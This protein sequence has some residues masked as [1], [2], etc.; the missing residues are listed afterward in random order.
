MRKAILRLSFLLLT[1]AVC[2]T[3][4]SQKPEPE[5]P[6]DGKTVLRITL[7]EP[8]VKTTLGPSV[9]GKRKVSWSEGDCVSLN[10]TASEPLSGLE[11][12]PSR[13]AFTFPGT[14]ATPYKLLYP[15]S[16]YK[17]ASTV[18]LPAVQTY[19]AGSFAT[20]TE[21]LCGYAES[22]TGDIT[23]S[24]LCA[25]VQLNIKKDPRVDV[26]TIES[27]VFKGNDGEQVS[28][29]FTIDY[30]TPAL[31]SASSAAADKLLTMSSIGQPLDE[32]DALEIF[33][34]VPARNYAHGFS[35]VI[36][37]DAGR[38]MSVKKSSATTLSVGKM[39]KMSAFTFVPGAMTIMDIEEEVLEMDDFTIKGR[40]VDNDGKPMEGVV[41]SDGHQCVRSMVDG[42][43]Y[44]ESDMAKV[45][46]VFVS[47]P[48]GYLPPV[49]GGIPR[50]YKAKAAASVSGGVYDFGDFVLTPVAN[51]DRFTL[52][53]SA[54]P[55]PR[56]NNWSLDK[57]AYK[58]LDI[59]EDL[60]REL[61]DVAGTISD[62]QVY[63]ICLGDLVHEN[64]SLFTNYENGLSQLG[65]PTYNIIGNHD[66]DPDAADDEAGAIPYESHF[67]P[68]NY[69]F[70]IGGIHFV[71]LDNLIMKKDGSSL[72][73][74]DQ[75]LTDDIW[76]WLQADMAF[77]PKETTIMVCAHSPMFKQQS[78][79]ERTNSAYHGG[80]R[81][82][83]DGNYGYG[84]LFDKYDEV[85]AWAGHTHR[86][87]NYIYPEAHRHKH[88]QVH[89]LAR[90]T[91]ELFTNEYLSGGTPRGFTIV[92]VDRGVISWRFHPTTR[93]TAT[94]QGVSSGY[95]SAGA[96]AYTWRD[97]TYNSAHV[98]VMNGGGSL[99]ED[100][101]L[102]VYPRGAYGDDNVYANVFLWDDLWENP[103]WTP[104]GGSPVEMTR[105]NTADNHDIISDTEKIYDLADTEFR[106]WY[107]TYANKSG[108]SLHDLSGYKTVDDDK[109][110]TLFRAP[111]SATPKSGTVTVTDRFGNTYSRTISW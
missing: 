12:E 111:A 11:E 15:A 4:C 41:V 34:V 22:A 29:D 98:A 36:T 9:D 5:I 97:W 110:T 96:P 87:F 45:K 107:K 55:Q 108:G 32:T 14:A 17:D 19:A 64:M 47:T 52:L 59:C 42:S 86:T 100:Y 80:T 20:N 72:T 31:S 40:V 71:M 6:S 54:D 75:G 85:H 26:A 46:F 24:H 77:V 69:S 88:V 27:V 67:G 37:D 30:A 18:T 70:N 8:M 61:A 84:D 2:L 90:S 1:A 103:V 68:R 73:A 21:P 78:G 82:N 50:F 60:Y 33:L 99:D 106:T 66:N 28:G 16:F 44:M 83:V 13:A 51:P 92:E 81:S 39:A 79:N 91:G 3:A 109:I 102:H 65:Y 62:R 63:G 104:T 57:I 35:A 94:F 89:T 101:Q 48:S 74:Y 93:Q 76:A 23:L 25:I 105:I 43:F 7:P 58:S 95:C 49:S 10:G 53:I 56:A 38:T